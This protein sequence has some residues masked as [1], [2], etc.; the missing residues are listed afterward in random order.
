MN[1]KYV[2]EKN[3]KVR[4]LKKLYPGTNI[5]IVFKHE[6]HTLLER[7]KLQEGAGSE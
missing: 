2:T 4:L 6:F 5:N 3:K 7:F 1:Q